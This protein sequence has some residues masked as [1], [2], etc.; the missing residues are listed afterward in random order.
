MADILAGSAHTKHRQKVPSIDLTPLVD[1]GFLLITFFVFTATLSNPTTM[2]AI[3]PAD[4]SDSSQVAASGAVSL[5][6]NSSFIQYYVGADPINAERIEINNANR[7][8]Q[9]LIWQ[10]Q[11]L[12]AIE[13]NDDKLFVMIKPADD[14]SFGMVVRLLDEMKICGIKRYTLTD[15][16]GLEKKTFFSD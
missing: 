5:I 1:L 6:V 4:S 8:R 12:I 14:A 7:L 2:T 10:Q 15:L 3:L 16:S 11:Q 9:T 13:G